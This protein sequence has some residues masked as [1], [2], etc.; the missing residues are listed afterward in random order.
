MD[1]KT[2]YQGYEDT[3]NTLK[4]QCAD[5]EK[6]S[7]VA[8]TNLNNLRQR[9]EQLIEECEVFSGVPMEKVPELLSQKKE[10]LDAI[11]AKLSGIDTTGPVTQEK[12][13]AIKAIT[14]EFS[15]NPVDIE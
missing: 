1:F 14:D 12:L 5:A 4:S 3:L 8:E 10:E 6:E 11:M 13:D 9:K 15:I 2:Q 7:I